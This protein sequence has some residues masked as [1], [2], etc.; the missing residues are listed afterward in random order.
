MA[1]R[2]SITFEIS[3]DFPGCKTVGVFETDG[4]GKGNARRA[5]KKEDP[6]WVIALS[7]NGDDRCPRH[8]GKKP[9]YSNLP[10]ASDKL[11][12][13]FIDLYY[14]KKWTLQD[15]GHKYGGSKSWAKRMMDEMGMERRAA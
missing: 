6:E 2:F 8:R 5:A 1:Q 11:R 4:G 9:N 15:I 14:R 7:G 12:E 10:V 3:C 13:E